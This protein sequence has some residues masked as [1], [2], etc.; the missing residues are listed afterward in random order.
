MLGGHKGDFYHKNRGRRKSVFVRI[1]CRNKRKTL[2]IRR[3][4]RRRLRFRN[5]GK[6]L[7]RNGNRVLRQNKNLRH[8]KNGR[9]GQNN[10]Q[11]RRSRRYSRKNRRHKRLYSRGRRRPFRTFEAAARFAG[12]NKQNKSRS[13]ISLKRNGENSC[14]QAA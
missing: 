8:D 9:K 3:Y 11:S 1:P 13:R 12:R 5:N 4:E 2:G 10:R 6:A 14:L 7:L